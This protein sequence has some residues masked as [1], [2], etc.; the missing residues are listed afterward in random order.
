MACVRA[1]AGAVCPGTT[2]VVAA[3]PR[4]R[5]G[6]VTIMNDFNHPFPPSSLARLGFSPDVDEARLAVSIDDDA[7]AYR[8]L[9]VT[10]EGCNLGGPEGSCPARIPKKLR[11]KSPPVVGDWVLT[12]LARGEQV[13]RTVLPRRTS[14]TRRAA[15]SE[16][17]GQVLAANVDTVLICMGLDQDFRLPRLE[18]WLSLVHDGGARPL[19]VLTKAGLVDAETR[20]ER[21]EACRG[22]ALDTEVLAI[23]VLEGLGIDAL[24]DALRHEHPWSLTMALLGSSGVGKS[25]LLNFLCGTNTM[26]TGATSQAH[27]KG[28]HTT[29]H[30]ELFA[31]PNRPL[32][33]VDTPG[34][35]EVGL[36]GDAHGVEQTF[37]DLVELARG[38][39]F[40]DC[41][42]DGEPGCAL[43]DAIDRGDLDPR[44]LDS[45]LALQDE[46]RKTARRA[47]EHEQRAHERRFSK[48]IRATLKAKGRR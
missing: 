9:R 38:C 19:V 16:H 21:V 24:D 25:T 18:R 36:W 17:R 46:Q 1:V 6:S 28:R 40:A 39:H 13:V 47:S 14:I 22:V 30:R 32:V 15:G 26:Q 33:L 41:S 29:S 12:R 43:E 35:R 2:F 31:V 23:D 8:V 44:R 4:D 10:A 3:A 20:R 48:L 7:V 11:T 42:H 5:S 34:L 45:W 27:G 37:A